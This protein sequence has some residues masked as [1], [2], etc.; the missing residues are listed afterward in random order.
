MNVRGG[1][2]LEAGDGVV[3]AGGRRG[4]VVDGEASRAEGL[5]VE[6][7][8]AGGAQTAEDPAVANV[9]QEAAL[10]DAAVSAGGWGGGGGSSRRRRRVGLDQHG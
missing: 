1:I 10:L 5:G 9:V 2:T 6:T 8:D 4:R 7:E 3:R